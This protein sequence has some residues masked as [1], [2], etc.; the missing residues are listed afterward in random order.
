MSSSLAFPTRFNQI[1]NTRLINYNKWAITC[2][3]FRPPSCLSLWMTLTISSTSHSDE[4]RFL[5]REKQHNARRKIAKNPRKIDFMREPMQAKNMIDEKLKQNKTIEAWHGELSTLSIHQFISSPQRRTS[6]DT[7]H[8]GDF[9]ARRGIQIESVN[10]IAPSSFAPLTHFPQLLL[11]CQRPFRESQVKGI[12]LE[13]IIR[14]SW[15]RNSRHSFNY[16]QNH[17]TL[18]HSW[19]FPNTSFP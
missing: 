15:H 1:D 10:V 4:D 9:N 5:R 13:A 8:C 18:I 6:Q 17:H 19:K 16:K 2:F 7:N 3:E 12:S 11:E 14:E